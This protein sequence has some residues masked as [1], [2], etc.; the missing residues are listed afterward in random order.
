MRKFARTIPLLFWVLLIACMAGAIEQWAFI[1]W[2]TVLAILHIMYDDTLPSW[3][4][5]EGRPDIRTLE[6]LRKYRRGEL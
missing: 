5:I 6:D 4:R 2:A 3:E 1:V